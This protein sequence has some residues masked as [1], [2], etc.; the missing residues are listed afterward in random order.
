[1]QPHEPGLSFSLPLALLLLPVSPLVSQGYLGGD[2]QPLPSG[3]PSWT[4]E[5][6]PSLGPC[7]FLGSRTFGGKSAERL[8]SPGS[9]L[10]QR[11]RGPRMLA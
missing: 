2:E 11:G 1:M 10:G 4:P 7:S 5:F 8:K 3:V 9:L 6:P